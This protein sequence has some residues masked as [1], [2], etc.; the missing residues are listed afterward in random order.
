LFGAARCANVIVISLES[1]QAFPIGLEVDGQPVMPNLTAFTRE[2]LYFPNYHEQTYLGTTSDAQFGVLQSLH[3]QPVGFVAMDYASNTFR[4]LPG[5]LSDRGYE[6]F[7]AV[8]AT[9]DFWN[10]DKLNPRY[11]FHGS[12]YEDYFELNDFLGSWL[13]DDQFFS[14]MVPRLEGRPGP[15]LA[16][17]QTSSNHH[18]YELPHHRQHLQIGRLQG[19]L[20]GDYLQSAH[21]FDQSFGRFVERLRAAGV[22]DRTVVV[23]YGDH[24]GFLGD[25][26]ELG[27]LLGRPQWTE[28][29][30]VSVRKR[31]PLVIRLPGGA[32]AGERPIIAGHLDV[33]PTVLGLL[34]IDI[35]DGD[36]GMMLGRDLTRERPS[37]VVFRDGGF[38]DD[39]HYYIQ[40]FG[41]ESGPACFEIA[42]G[43]PV[44]CILLESQR[45][46]ARERL[47][48]SDLIVQGDLIPLL[49]DR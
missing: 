5:I 8:A 27:E 28:W 30:R 26:L 18:P 12:Y 11:G 25:P 22:L 2:S 49:G 29:D 42:S 47:E 6:T 44:D 4:A 43:Q 10:A 16:Y 38:A 34:G 13:S 21:L 40:R 17:M 19:T 23:L 1:L 7:S 9:S 24:Q 20:L 33:A 46:A 31:T 14:Q 15:F 3:P 36:Y 45:R 41:T 48:I 39:T 35:E 37:M 32:H